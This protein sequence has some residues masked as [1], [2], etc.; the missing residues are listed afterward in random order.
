MAHSLI[1]TRLLEVISN[2]RAGNA[3]RPG[4]PPFPDFQGHFHGNED[5]LDCWTSRAARWRVESS[6][7]E[8]PAEVFHRQQGAA[9]VRTRHGASRSG[10]PSGNKMLLTITACPGIRPITIWSSR[11]SQTIRPWP[12]SVAHAWASFWAACCVQCGRGLPRT[13][14]ITSATPDGK[15]IAAQPCRLASHAMVFPLPEWRVHQ[16]ESY[17]RKRLLLKIGAVVAAIQDAPGTTVEDFVALLDVALEHELDLACDI[18][19]YGPTDYP[20]TARLLRALACKVPGFEFNSL[21]RWLSLPG[22][23]EQLMGE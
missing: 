2:R 1:S 7:D 5:D 10:L 4:K 3:K 22:Q 11:L 14:P 16:S 6:S 9:L 18:A 12:I 21:R 19:F 17:R 23:F 15:I 8:A 13:A 20:M